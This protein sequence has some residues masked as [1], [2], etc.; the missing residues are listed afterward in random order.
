MELEHAGKRR[1]RGLR[2]SGHRRLRTFGNWHPQRP[3]SPDTNLKA[4]QLRAAAATM[5]TKSH[6]LT[7]GK[8][9]RCSSYPMQRGR[10]LRRRSLHWRPPALRQW[11][12]CF[13]A[14]E[15]NYDRVT[16]VLKTRPISVGTVVYRSWAKGRFKEAITTIDPEMLAKL[17]Y[18]GLPGHDAETLILSLDQS[19][20]DWRTAHVLLQRAGVSRGILLACKGMWEHH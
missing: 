5:Q 14:K 16:D 7:T 2:C 8:Q 9:R 4:D 6:G 1:K 18:G 13:I 15:G 12:V 11:R 20:A 19:S 3:I 10:D 17:Q